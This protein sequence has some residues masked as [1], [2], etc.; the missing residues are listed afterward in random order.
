M[1][2]SSV[3]SSRVGQFD[4]TIGRNQKAEKPDTTSPSATGDAMPYERPHWVQV[5]RLGQSPHCQLGQTPH[6]ERA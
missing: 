2:Y 1:S 4:F 6:T 3:C 5:S